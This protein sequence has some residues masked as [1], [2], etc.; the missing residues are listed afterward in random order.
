MIKK[1][2]FALSLLLYLFANFYITAKA[3]ANSAFTEALVLVEGRNYVQAAQRLESLLQKPADLSGL[4]KEAIYHVLAYCYESQ[5]QWAKAA[6][7]YQKAIS[8]TYNL[9]D[10][11]VYH[12]AGLYQKMD[13]P[14]NAIIWY[15]RLIDQHPQSFHFAEAKYEIAQAYQSQGNYTRALDYLSGLI[16][17]KKSGYVRQATFESARAYEG[18]QNWKE[19]QLTY[20]RLID[21]DASDDIARSALAR[22]QSLTQAHRE[23]TITR[24]QRMSHGMVLYHQGKIEDARAKFQAVA[25]GYKDA[26]AGQATYHIGLAYYRQRQYDLALKEFNQVVSLSPQSGYLMRALYQITLCYRRKDEPDMA[27]KRLKDFIDT[28]ESSGDGLVE[29]AMYDLGWVQENQKQYD[30]ALASYR[31]LANKYPRNKLLPQTY[32]RMGWMQFKQKRYNESIETFT[33]LMKLFPTDSYALAAHF[34]IAKSYERQGQ[35]EAA[36]KKYQ[37]LAESNQWYYSFRA[38]E[39][40]KNQLARNQS[41]T[42]SVNRSQSQTRVISNSSL[43]KNIGAE[44]TPRVEKLMTLRFYEDAITELRGNIQLN[45]SKLKDN[46]YNLFLC[47]Q[48][49][50]RFQEAQLY[51]EKVGQ[52]ESASRANPTLPQ[53]LYQ[54]LYRVYYT[55]IIGKHANQYQ[56][57]PLFVAAMIREESRYNAKILS[58]AGAVGL[59]QI[60]PETGS[61]LAQRLRLGPFRSDMLYDAD[62][63]IQMGTSY[64]KQLMEQ[65]ENNIALVAG[66][67]NGGPN[68][69]ERW[70]R[71]MNIPD[72]DEFIEDIPIVETRRHIKKVLD[73]YYMYQ[74][75][76]SNLNLLGAEKL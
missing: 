53:E 32:W 49:L 38:R 24:D 68:R 29:D 12:L 58:S 55:D 67:Y 31:R 27:Q 8:P 26:L 15:Q 56:M 36:E 63:N 19:A 4:E 40:L 46:Y 35:W 13:D 66:A 64:M 22:L 7:S 48:K 21:A 28:Y 11:A 73:S 10:Y 9:A 33:T 20:Q 42:A 65:F 39:Q 2:L 25:K 51:A 5:N 69:M 70:V 34:W 45:L 23:L 75:L 6:E 52:L 76:Y 60:M 59:M 47:Y 44:K 43:L 16:A 41:G 71:E 74:E 54:L 61:E 1:I 37:E 18:L 62:I 3:S 30:E 50:E 17:D 72:M 57:D 14:Q